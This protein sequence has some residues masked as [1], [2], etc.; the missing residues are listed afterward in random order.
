VAGA[1]DGAHDARSEED[2]GNGSNPVRRHVGK[3]AD[4]NDADDQN[5]GAE[6]IE[7]ERHD[8]IASREGMTWRCD[9]GLG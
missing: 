4:V 7:S 6:K 2:D 9:A 8:E 3:V 5:D 1:A